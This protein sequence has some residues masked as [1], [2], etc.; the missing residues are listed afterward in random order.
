[1]PA[2]RLDLSPWTDRRRRALV[3]GIDTWACPHLHPLRGCRNDARRLA[4]LLATRFDFGVVEALDEDATREAILDA[5][6]ALVDTDDPADEVVLAWSGHGSRIIAGPY[7]TFETLVPADSHHLDKGVATGE[8]RDLTDRELYGFLLALPEST[9]PT[10]LIDACRSGGIIRELA[11]RP[12]GVE[13]DLRRDVLTDKIAFLRVE[14]LDTG[15]AIRNLATPPPLDKP[16]GRWLPPSQRYTLLASCADDEFC[17]EMQDPVTERFHG[18]FSLQ[19]AETLTA[20]RAP[21]SWRELRDR[22]THRVARHNAG[23]TAQLEGAVD[24]QVFADRLLRPEPF[25]PVVDATRTA[26]TLGGGSAT[27][28]GVD[29]TW[30]L[31][32]TE[33]R[34]SDGDDALATVRVGAVG[35]THAAARLVQNDPSIDEPAD[36]A[37]LI[38]SRAFEVGRPIERR[39]GVLVDPL[40]GELGPVVRA[41]IAKS[42]RLIVVDTSEAADAVVHALPP[43]ARTEPSDPLPHLAPLTETTWA[44]SDRAGERQL[45]PARAIGRTP[46]E[47]FAEALVADLDAIARHH[48]LLGLRHPEPEH[49]L[50]GDLVVTMLRRRDA[51]GADWQ[52]VAPGSR[53]ALGDRFAL[54][55]EREPVDEV[56]PLFVAVL[57]LGLSG[58]IQLLY[59]PTGRRIPW[60]LARLEI[61][62][63]TDDALCV[64]LP[65]G[66]P[67]AGDPPFSHAIETVLVLVTR[68]FADFD[69]LTQSGP[70][71]LRGRGR[72]PLDAV[73]RRALGLPTLRSRRSENLLASPHDWGVAA[74]PFEVVATRDDAS[75]GG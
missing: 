28:V 4:E 45:A 53:Y 21:T 13:P 11:P 69:L 36:L 72:S 37:T 50:L 23:Q 64:E 48:F 26:L 41:A 67:F 59:P 54:R 74:C 15:P 27:G 55:V 71:A 5:M 73:L 66:F 24:R 9:H 3:V 68:D 52:T 16:P 12:R 6:R 29:S 60:R 34:R 42:P 33:T 18:I 62:M 8:N 22:L 2:P 7:G 10:L 61:G 31:L 46:P 65:T 70:G 32:P 40:A 1:M 19:L 39:F 75:D 44:I 56:E 57:D 63:R 43:R 58:S 35:P 47:R 51:P 38:G 14:D 25:L 20:M 30:R 49:S 17:R